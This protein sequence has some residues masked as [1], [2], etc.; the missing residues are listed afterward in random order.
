MEDLGMWSELEDEVSTGPRSNPQ[1]EGRFSRLKRRSIRWSKCTAIRDF[2][3][4]TGCSG[5]IK[6]V[7]Y[8][9]TIASY[10]LKC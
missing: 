2:M 6:Y 5:D 8:E 1:S 10:R 3:K 4:E 7:K 9:R